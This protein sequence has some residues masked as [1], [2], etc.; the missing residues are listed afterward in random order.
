MQNHIFY[1]QSSST[2][3]MCAMGESAQPLEVTIWVAISVD[4]NGNEETN[5]HTHTHT[6]KK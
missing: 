3:L 1:Y 6:G 2:C 5:T 4:I